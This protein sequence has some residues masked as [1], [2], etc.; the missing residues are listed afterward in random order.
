V[1]FLIVAGYG[2][3]IVLPDNGTP[4]CR[5]SGLAPLRAVIPVRRIFAYGSRLWSNPS[6]R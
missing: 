4:D 5:R 3:R 2:D 1:T 6:E